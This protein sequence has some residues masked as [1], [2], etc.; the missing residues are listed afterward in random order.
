MPDDSSSSARRSRSISRSARSSSGHAIVWPSASILLCRVSAPRGWLPRTDAMTLRHCSQR[1]K[2]AHKHF[3][4]QRRV[5]SRSSCCLGLE[6]TSSG[7]S[8]RCLLPRELYDRS[9]SGTAARF[10][11]MTDGSTTYSGRSQVDGSCASISDRSVESL[12]LLQSTQTGHPIA[13]IDGHEAV[14]GKCSLGCS[15]SAASR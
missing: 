13:E 8:P 6:V 10:P 2:E 9:G 14:I 11:V 5:A 12:E 4:H 7:R 1:V 3:H 15:T